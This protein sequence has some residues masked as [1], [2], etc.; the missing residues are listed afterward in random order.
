MRNSFSFVN[1]FILVLY[2]ITS[3]TSSVFSKILLIFYFV[4]EKA[5]TKGFP[6]I[7]TSIPLLLF[8][9]NFSKFLPKNL[10]WEITQLRFL[11]VLKHHFLTVFC[12]LVSALSKI[13]SG[14]CCDSLVFI[15]AR[16]DNGMIIWCFH[17]NASF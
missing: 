6:P 10:N 13:N 17:L 4:S 7:I 11:K 1:V 5:I 8:R 3:K 12:H 2:L 15:L 16:D 14:Y 9:V